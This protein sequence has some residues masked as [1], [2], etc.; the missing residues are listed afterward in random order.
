M[1]LSSCA[2]TTE[3]ITTT[4]TVYVLPP[5]GL[6]VPCYKPRVMATTAK[7]LSADT[8]KLKSALR[9]CAQYVDDYL[10]WREMKHKP[11]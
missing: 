2:K 10:K 9:E 8:L 3:Y 4:E 7:E 11:D 5:S 1:L 6:V